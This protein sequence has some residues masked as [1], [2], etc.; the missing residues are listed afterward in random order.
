MTLEQ[1][2]TYLWRDMPLIGWGCVVSAAVVCAGVAVLLEGR[3]IMRVNSSHARMRSVTADGLVVQTETASVSQ[4]Y[5]YGHKIA[6][7]GL[8]MMLFAL[9]SFFGFLQ[10]W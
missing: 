2:I 1:L 8:M 10:L 5:W 4:D 7:T 3:A 9:I 6:R